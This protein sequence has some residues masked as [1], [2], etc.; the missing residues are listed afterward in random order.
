MKVD[1]SPQILNVKPANNAETLDDKR[2][3][4][5]ATLLNVSDRATATISLNGGEKQPMV[6]EGA[7]VRYTPDTDL[8]DGKTE[9]T[10]T[11][12]DGDVVKEYS[13]KFYVGKATVKH[14]RGQIHSHS[15]YSDGAGTPEEAVQYASTAD[16]IDFFSLTDHSNYFDKEGNLGT[17]DDEN[18]GLK[19]PRDGSKSKWKRYKEIVEAARTED[20]LP[21]YGY[22]MTWTKT[23]ANYGHMNTYNT[24]G[25]VSRNDAILNNKE[26][27][28][29][30]LAYYEM[31][32]DLDQTTF[33][34]FNHPGETFGTFDDFGHYDPK[35][36][37][38]VKLVEIGN[39]E[40][41]IPSQGYFP[42]YNEY[43]KALDKGWKLAPSINQDNHKKKWGDANEGRTVVIAD[44][45]TK[46]NVIEAIRDLKVYATE[47]KDLTI[48]YEIDGKGMGA[49]VENAKD[50][51]QVRIA[52]A[53]QNEES[54]GTVELLTV[55]GKVIKTLNSAESLA[56]FEFDQPNDYPYY[57]VRVTEADGDVALTAPI[58][59]GKVSA[60]GIDSLTPVGNNEAVVGEEKVLNYT[61]KSD[62]AKKVDKVEVLDGD[63][64]IGTAE[65][66]ELA[67]SA[68]KSVAVTPTEQGVRKWT[69]RLKADGKVFTKDVQVTV[70]PADLKTVPISDAQKAKEGEVVQVEGQLTSNVSGY[71]KNTAF[72]DASYIQDATGGINI[73]PIAE[74]LK[75]GA[76]VRIKGVKSAYQG[77]RQINIT[78]I[79]VLDENATPLAPTDLKTGAVKD[80]LGLLVKTKGTVKKVNADKSEIVIDD[81]SGEIRVFID[82]YIG[83][84]GVADKSMPEIAVG[85]T[86][87]AIGLSSID[88]D[89]NRIRVR[90]RNDIRVNGDAEAPTNPEQ[91]EQPEKPTDPKEPTTPPSGGN[92]PGTWRPIFGGLFPPAPE[93]SGTE[94]TPAPEETILPPKYFVDVPKDAWFK[95]AVDRMVS[96]GIM[97]GVGDDEFAPARPASRGM[98]LT[99]L[100]RMAGSPAAKGDVPFTDVPR[101]KWYAEAV[102]WAYEA[103]VA[104][105]ISATEFG[106]DRD[107]TRE[108]LATLLY[109]YFLEKGVIAKEDAIEPIAGASPW[110][111][112]A[113]SWAKKEGI[114]I[115]RGE[116]GMA[117]KAVA[118]RAEIATIFTRL[119]DK[120]LT[121]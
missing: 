80:N 97:K 91:P 101:D 108:Q 83:R 43:F 102:R 119:L 9:A 54:I 87:E 104:K 115:G 121:K 48:E 107:I 109:R 84:P 67:G 49:T 7:L 63:K 44:A 71:D 85:D 62:S 82:G 17:I 117:P 16:H 118:T 111:Q 45:L 32:K 78:S 46:E 13:W 3:E 86:L 27:S 28:K 42:S 22:E 15:N 113:L 14:Y 77:E 60:E 70:F 51:L 65:G 72:F 33:S 76:K 94:K 120:G 30:L 106:A 81:G 100:H 110:A 58:W 39:G 75:E 47:D 37:E 12:T 36:N 38:N 89:G 56:S 4:I 88:P 93:T 96:A 10:I 25:F 73:F 53:E 90:N 74:N 5:S 59:T 69:L 19:D 18:S 50:K 68:Q 105:G 61:F 116:E 11:V 41:A 31:L 92:T 24:E 29:G 99:M 34:Q 23:G 112:E 1:N 98:I 114:L 21:I 66:Y 2:P 95:D 8:K 55:G 52:V 79:E 57:V 20:F 26:G 64:V 35:V 6:R 103:G 40:G